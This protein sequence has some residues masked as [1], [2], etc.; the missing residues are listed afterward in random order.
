MNVTTC[1]APFGVCVSHEEIQIVTLRRYRAANVLS[2]PRGNQGVAAWPFLSCGHV[3]MLR[4]L[5]M[6]GI[7]CGTTC[8]LAIRYFS[9]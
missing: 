2:L 1:C 9:V 7:S 6:R 4:V 8:R 3:Q 5:V